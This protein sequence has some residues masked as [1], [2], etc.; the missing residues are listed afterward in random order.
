LSARTEKD[1]LAW[2]SSE[3]TG[4]FATGTSA[5]VETTALAVQALLKYGKGAAIAAKALRY[6]AAKKDAAG[7]WGTT[8]AT[9]MALRALL[10]STEKSA[11]DVQGTLEITLNG[12][13]VDTLTLNPE[14][15]DLFHQLVFPQIDPRS[16]NT[17]A[18]RFTGRGGLAYQ[19]VGR[20]FI[21]WDQRPDNEPLS[22]NVTYDRTRLTEDDIATATATIKNNLTKA[23]NMVMVDLGIPPGFD[24][25]SEDLERY[26]EES[27]RRR[28]GRLQKFTLTA[29]QA[30]LYFDCFAPGETATVKFR[31]RAKY[32]IRARTF[33]SRVYEY[34]EPE[35][36][37]VA[38][39]VEL[40]VDP[41]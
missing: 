33:Q 26:Q 35:V 17:V 24:L 8:Q 7:T 38:A 10:L 30:I 4:V 34:Y 41:H 39:P 6:I 32:P 1:D 21:P 27:A 11:N 9:I 14:N 18:L 29:T 5:S 23:A 12:R 28:S 25:A 19:V 3:E 40:E 36:Q 15:S 37:S 20:Y 22:I 31:L 16:A 13:A 2:W